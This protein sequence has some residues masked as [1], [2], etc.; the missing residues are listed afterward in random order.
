MLTRA[1]HS[2]TLCRRRVRKVEV[3][4]PSNEAPSSIAVPGHLAEL[5]AGEVPA[6]P[7]SRDPDRE[8]FLKSL[9]TAWQKGDVRPTHAMPP[10]SGGLANTS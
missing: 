6:L 3:P 9:R 4:I 8:M 1:Q 2:L 7:A 5:A 10:T